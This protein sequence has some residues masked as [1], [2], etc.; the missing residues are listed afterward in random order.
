MVM[1]SKKH[2]VS[3]ALSVFWLAMAAG[4]AFAADRPPAPGEI[5]PP[6]ELP[7]PQDGKVKDYLGLSGSGSFTVPQI[8]AKL[9]IVEIYSMY[10][11]H[12]QRGAAKVNEL[13]HAIQK[14]PELRDKIKMIGI[15]AGNTPFEVDFFRETYDVPFPLFPDQDLSI[16]KALGEVRTP[17]FI[18]VRIQPEETHQV[19]YSRL[20][21]FE[22]AGK[23]L[24][25]V[26]DLSGLE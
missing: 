9:V 11:P 2:F 7:M 5:L 1:A 15:A 25:L 13:Y 20:G 14:R 8:K 12:C 4:P 18:G 26:I 6:F 21:G 10:C 24:A 16:H 22:D 19:V 17:Y 23:F 3:F